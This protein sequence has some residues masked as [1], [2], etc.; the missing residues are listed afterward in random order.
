MKLTSEFNPDVS[1]GRRVLVELARPGRT[2]E[3]AVLIQTPFG[4]IWPQT[5]REIFTRERPPSFDPANDEMTLDVMGMYCRESREIKIFIEL[6]DQF[7]RRHSL[8]GH[9]VEYIVRLHEYAHA[10]THLGV[11]STCDLD[12]VDAFVAGRSAILACADTDT[13]EILAQTI[14][15]TALIA[16]KDDQRRASLQEL[17]LSVMTHQPARY[18]LSAKLRENVSVER[19][20]DLLA[21]LHDGYLDLVQPGFALRRPHADQR[22]DG[23]RGTGQAIVAVHRSRASSDSD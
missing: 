9:D 11:A 16:L 8:Q 4:G 20:R 15:W 17:F 10:M 3:P 19:V 18:Q 2:M 7:R 5:P 21:D 6:I 22:T 1:R 12:D 13:H 14:A 23:S